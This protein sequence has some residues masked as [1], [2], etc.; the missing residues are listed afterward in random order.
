MNNVALRT[1]EHEDP[2]ESHGLRLSKIDADLMGETF[3]ILAESGASL[4]LTDVTFRITDGSRRFQA[5]W[6]EIGAFSIKDLLA[7]RLSLPQ[8]HSMRRRICV[9]VA[10]ELSLLSSNLRDIGMVL[11]E[12]DSVMIRETTLS[13]AEPFYGASN[14][15]LGS[16]TPEQ[17][18]FLAMRR[19]SQLELHAC[20]EVRIVHCFLD[21]VMLRGGDTYISNSV[22]AAMID[23]DHTEDRMASSRGDAA[24]TAKSGDHLRAPL[25]VLRDSVVAPMFKFGDLRFFG[26]RFD[27]HGQRDNSIGAGD[28]SLVKRRLDEDLSK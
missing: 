23:L 24:N 3:A 4:L 8:R 1:D 9:S 2:L 27:E 21:R 26:L 11:R 18:P 16:E 15:M 7:L 25:M 5:H 12:I 19:A 22:I 10:E 13:D 6:R 20:K 28:N 17:N 14:W